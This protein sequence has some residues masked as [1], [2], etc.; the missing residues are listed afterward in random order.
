MEIV[1]FI[2]NTSIEKY[3]ICIVILSPK[4]SSRYEIIDK[5]IF[6]SVRKIYHLNYLR[7][8]FFKKNQKSTMKKH[9]NYTKQV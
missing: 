3:K 4:S 9:S 1:K 2:K 8:H 6:Q 7:K 5:N